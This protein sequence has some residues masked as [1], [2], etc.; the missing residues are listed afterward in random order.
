M[1]VGGIVSGRVLDSSASAGGTSGSTDYVADPIL[2][3]GRSFALQRIFDIVG[4][5]VAII[6][7]APVLAT[8]P[9]VLKWKYPNVPV[10]FGNPVVGKG[11]RPFRMWKFSTMIPNAHVI[12]DEILTSDEKLKKEWEENV[13][14]DNDPRILPGLGAFLRRTS[15]N[16]LPQFFNVLKGDMSLVG[17]RPITKAEEE[18]YRRIGGIAMLARRHAQ[19]PGVTGLW[20]AS[21]RSNVS[22]EE[23]VRLDDTYLRSQSIWFDIKILCWTVARVVSRDGAV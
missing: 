9:V 18:R 7:F 13:K 3:H 23:R 14:L 6:L 15:I 22:Y 2:G 17:P 21:G 1:D 5:V 19:R 8:I 16:E 10:L 20:Q 4:S 12:I 11:G